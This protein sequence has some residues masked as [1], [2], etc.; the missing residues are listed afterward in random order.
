MARVRASLDHPVQSPF[1]AD[2]RRQLP[3]LG[4]DAPSRDFGTAQ[5]AVT[6]GRRNDP[7]HL[8]TLMRNKPPES[9]LLSNCAG[10][11]RIRD[12]LTTNWSP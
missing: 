12:V 2:V 5:M 9:G 6:K 4:R 7:Q 8:Q 1:D 11:S 3:P 10:L